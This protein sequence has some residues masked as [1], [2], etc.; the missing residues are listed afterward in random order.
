MTVERAQWPRES[1][2]IASNGC[3]RITDGVILGGTELPLLLPG[4]DIAGCRCSTPP[5]FMWRR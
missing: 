2:G 3:A 1:R 4:T 5:R